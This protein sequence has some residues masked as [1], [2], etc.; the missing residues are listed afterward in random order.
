[1][2]HGELLSSCP[3]QTVEGTLPDATLNVDSAG[4]LGRRKPDG[5][6]ASHA[7]AA[8]QPTITD[9]SAFAHRG[10]VD[11]DLELRNAHRVD[12]IALELNALLQP[13][14][15]RRFLAEK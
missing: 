6:S 7:E 10:A 15:C 4:T 1:M 11:G 9:F 5:G 2:S 14:F 13:L 3:G 8:H 12:R